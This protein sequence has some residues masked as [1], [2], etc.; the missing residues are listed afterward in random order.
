MVF[1]REM[2]RWEA[3]LNEIGTSLIPARSVSAQKRF[4]AS[5]LELFPHENEPVVDE[6]DSSSG[7]L[8]IHSV[9]YS[10]WCWGSIS[11]ICMVMIQN[12]N[13]FEELHSSA[14]E[15]QFGAMFIRAPWLQAL[16]TIS[17]LLSKWPFL[18]PVQGKVNYRA[19]CG[20][21]GNLE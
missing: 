1:S 9:L 16:M 7:N 18:T 20:F 15:V 14:S 2:W 3:I 13:L 4:K 17:N 11:N 19:E 12:S 6:H 10:G 8:L 5:R 21:P